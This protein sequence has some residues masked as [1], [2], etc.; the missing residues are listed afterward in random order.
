MRFSPYFC[1]VLLTKMLERIKIRK[2]KHR[3]ESELINTEV[4]ENG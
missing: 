2:S 3:K 1:N 4:E